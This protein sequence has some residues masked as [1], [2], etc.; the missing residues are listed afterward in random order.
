MNR[1]LASTA[2]LLGLLGFAP[3]ASAGTG[4]IDRGASD[5]ILAQRLSLNGS[6]AT[7]TA[8]KALGQHYGRT[9]RKGTKRVVNCKQFSSDVWRCRISWKA[10]HASYGGYVQLISSDAGVEVHVHVKRL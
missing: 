9:W 6:Q 3:I 5:P 7:A 4:P 1:R 10:G 2:V 8:T